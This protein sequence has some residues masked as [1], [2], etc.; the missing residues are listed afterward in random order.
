MSS[1]PPDIL[2]SAAQAGF[3]AREASRVSDSD[4]AGQI[5]TANRN[6]DAANDAAESVETGD[7]DTAVFTDAQGA[8]GQGRQSEQPEDQPT[9]TV[10]KQPPEDDSTNILDIKA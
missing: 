8:G 1:I 2:G 3:T 9:D 5:R 10:Q 6:V 7:G 4:R